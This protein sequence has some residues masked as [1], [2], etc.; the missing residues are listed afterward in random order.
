M[1]KEN[2]SKRL[3]QIMAKTGLKQ[4]DII[5]KCKPICDK[6]SANTGKKIKVTKTDLSQWI[7]GKYEP[8]QWKLTILS[9]ALNVS[10]VWLMGYDVSE[11]LLNSKESKSDIALLV[12][13]YENIL[14][15]ED[16]EYIKFTIEKRKKENHQK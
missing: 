9:E 4:I 14:T 1:R 8:G 2:T 6:Y 7:A 3:K 15:D 10:P 5:N 13:E 11:E 16:K 12:E